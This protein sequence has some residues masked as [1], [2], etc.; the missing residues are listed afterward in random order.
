MADRS[1]DVPR[2]AGQV[3]R[4]VLL[5]RNIV[6]DAETRSLSPTPS[7]PCSTPVRPPGRRVDVGVFPGR[8]RAAVLT[9]RPKLSAAGT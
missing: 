2:N 1:Q 9:R 3:V 6:I 5:R 4:R 8:L 7:R